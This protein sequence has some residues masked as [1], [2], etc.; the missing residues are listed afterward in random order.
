MKIELDHEK[1][2]Y[3]GRIDDR[4][5][6]RP[7][8]IFPA[9]SL[10]FRFRGIG[11]SVV[12]S[13]RKG[14]WDNYL[15]IIVD[16]QQRK[17]LLPESGSTRICLA[18]GLEDKPHEVMIFKRQDSCHE[19]IL[20]E[21]VLEEGGKLLDPPAKPHRRI[22]VYGDS[23]SAGE[24]SEAVEFAGKPDPEHNGE[25]SNSWYSYSWMT[26]RMLNA[27]IHDVAQG[28][29]ALLD[30]TGWFCDPYFMGMETAWDKVHYNPALSEA[31]SWDF[32][33][34]RPHV[35]IVAIGQNDSHPKDYMKEDFHGEK[36]EAW[37]RVY[38]EWIGKIRKVYPRAAIILT[39]TILCH[40]SAWD[41]AIHQ[42]WKK[43]KD[44]RIY[45]FLYSRNGSGTPG[46]IRIP[47]AE[48]MAQEL[49]AFIRTLPEEIWEDEPVDTSNN[50]GRSVYE[51]KEAV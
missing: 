45:H 13:N 11:A 18:Q 20:E 23:V 39:T 8:L 51:E 2:L 19:L 42:V 34:Y 6:K 12:I 1:L 27:Q 26:A 38:A 14:C 22:E 37:R 5:P 36:A 7:E 40:D 41:R 35:V 43:L 15:G 9:S 46:H 30:G 47:E 50:K 48:K 16:G 17:V 25:Y 29:I 3:S 44:E 21:L 49:S 33:R 4:N 24:V 28:G 32:S 10:T 31:T